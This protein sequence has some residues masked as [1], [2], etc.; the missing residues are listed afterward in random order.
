LKLII[1]WLTRPDALK[2]SKII[3][4][5]T[6][7]L[8]PVY[9]MWPQKKCG[10][11]HLS[12][13]FSSPLPQMR[14]FSGKLLR[15]HQG[16]E[17]PMPWNKTKDPYRIWLSE[18]ILQQTRVNQ[19]M[20]YYERL[21]KN[22]PT[23]EHLAGADEDAVLKAWEG[24]GYYSRARNLHA[25]AKQ[26]VQ[27]FRGKFPQ[28]HEE[29][30]T[31][32]GIGPYS[33]SAIASFAF[34]LPHAVVDGNVFRLLSRYFG[35]Q[36]PIDTSAGKKI[37]T[38]LAQQLLDK[39]FPGEHNQAIMNFGAMVCKPLRPDCHV[40]IFGKRCYALAHEQVFHLP[41]KQKKKPVRIRWFN[42]LVVE[43]KGSFIIE[44]RKGD[45]IWK[46]LYQFPLVEATNA[47]TIDNIEKT[48][49]EKN[50]F[51]VGKAVIKE[52]SSPVEHKLTHQTIITR[53][54]K[55]Q[56]SVKDNTMI[57]GWLCVKKNGLKKFSFPKVIDNYLKNC[58][59]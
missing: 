20:S 59:Y 26:I 39:K 50:I 43:N 37:F 14:G 22:F 47:S 27:Q 32:K 51:P 42:Y 16:N 6:A 53:F 17:R 34:G 41:V 38:D 5:L 2:K 11:L 10:C 31:L 55:V 18:I 3:K 4:K 44:K 35:I 13:G 29:L 21:I 1:P 48:L 54:I 12:E 45:D 23:V 36:E 46:G 49:K 30:L 56:L 24:L 25:A 15:W 58:L 57:N 40:C 33:A 19:G 7:N 28:K 52:V 9:S 8:C